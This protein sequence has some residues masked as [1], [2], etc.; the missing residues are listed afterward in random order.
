MSPAARLSLVV[1]VCLLA[2]GCDTTSVSGLN[3]R[4]GPTTLSP[5]VATIDRVDTGIGIDCFVYG[6]PVHGDPVWY[7]IDRPHSGYVTNHYVD[8]GGDGLA[9]IPSC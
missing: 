7:R 8:T 1:G 9:D 6:E 4:A 5:V 3:V 2:T